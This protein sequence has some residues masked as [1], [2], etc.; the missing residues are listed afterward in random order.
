MSKSV[1]TFVAT[2]E[3]QF[4]YSTYGLG[5]VAT[6]QAEMTRDL[7]PSLRFARAIAVQCHAGLG[8]NSAVLLID[9]A[10]PRNI[11][12]RAKRHTAN[13]LHTPRS[14]GHERHKPPLGQYARIKAESAAYGRRPHETATV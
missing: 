3:M 7:V 14:P 13:I 1:Q 12:E 6:A 2:T 9:A 8:V 5:D 4:H 10:A 11:R